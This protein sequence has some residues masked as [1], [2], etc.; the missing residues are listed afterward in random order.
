LEVIVPPRPTGRRIGTVFAA[1]VE[2]GRA[3]LAR[4]NVAIEGVVT[5]HRADMQFQGQSHILPVAI[6]SAAISLDELR[7]LFA[8]AYRRRFG[9]ELPEIRPVLV[10]LHT[11]VI[12]RR[13]PVSLRSI[14]AS[15]PGDDLGAARRTTRPV[16]FEEAGWRDTPVYARERLP[17]DARFTGPAIVEQLDCTSVIAPGDR[18]E[19]DPIGNLV[20]TV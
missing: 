2:A 4:E 1:Q 18:V 14:A 11:A 15:A 17:A 19:L 20:V 3:R 7:A 8:T 16:W 12:G 13:K 5:V 10:N 6:A 9:V